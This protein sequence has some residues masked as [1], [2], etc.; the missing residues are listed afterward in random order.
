MR[1]S[2][3][4]L[5]IL[6]CATPLACSDTTNAPTAPA[7]VPSFSAA[8][9]GAVITRGEVVFPFDYIAFGACVNEPLHIYGSMLS[10]YKRVESPSGALLYTEVLVDPRWNVVGVNSGTVWQLDRSQV[11]VHNFG[12]KSARFLVN[13]NDWYQ[14]E[15]MDRLRI[16][17]LLRMVWNANGELVTETMNIADCHLQPAH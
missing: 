8:D 17:W 10:A 6:A 2:F 5:A 16:Q 15:A 13:E 9:N 4:F 1:R 11:H 7:P 14:N 3:R 12:F